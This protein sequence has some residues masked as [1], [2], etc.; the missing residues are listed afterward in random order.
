M[1]VI[2]PCGLFYLC[3]RSLLFGEGLFSAKRRRT[4]HEG[5]R[6]P[7]EPGLLEKYA[8]AGGRF[9]E[10]SL[11]RRTKGNPCRSYVNKGL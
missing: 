2:V 6:H 11:A 9:F 3:I 1:G 4:V 5:K 10:R 8:L 7:S